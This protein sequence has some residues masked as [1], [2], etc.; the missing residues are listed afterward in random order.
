MYPNLN[1]ELARVGITRLML[2]AKLG[3]TPGTLSLKLNG[4]SDLSLAECVKIKEIVAPEKTLEYLF[5]SNEKE[6][7]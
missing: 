1:A 2:A 7:E 4:K 3:V 5:A 6:V